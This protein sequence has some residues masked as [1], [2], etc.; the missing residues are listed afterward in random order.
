MVAGDGSKSRCL[1][2][3]AEASL[4]NLKVLHI[5]DTAILSDHFEELL[6]SCPVLDELVLDV[7]H[8]IINC[9]C[10]KLNI[11]S[12]TL[13]RLTMRLVTCR[14][15]VQIAINSPAL[16][17]LNYKIDA[18]QSLML[19]SNQSLTEVVIRGYLRQQSRMYVNFDYANAL[20]HDV[21]KEINNIH[22]LQIREYV[23]RGLHYYG[24]QL[25]LFSKLTYLKVYDSTFIFDAR[26]LE[27]LLAEC[28]VLETLIVEVNH[29]PWLW[30]RKNYM[31]SLEQSRLVDMLCHLKIFEIKLLKIW[32]AEA[33]AL[34]KLIEF[35]LNNANVLE[36]LTVLVRDFQFPL[37]K[38]PASV[39]ELLTTSPRISKKCQVVFGEWR[40]N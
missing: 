28:I 20:E 22:S 6:S 8:L 24:L 5:K 17:Y 21:L 16:E 3:P 14:S 38:Q 26:C 4:P 39:R 32:D 11:S 37:D 10:F 33:K 35:F 40:N 29:D 2:I 12:A 18:R 34:M 36:K 15:A 27:Y 19:L 31:F 7:C 30:R 25:P 9:D 1:K 13:K 23:L